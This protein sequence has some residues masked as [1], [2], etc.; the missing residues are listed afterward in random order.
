MLNTEQ[1]PLKSLTPHP[2]NVRQGDVGAIVE[3]L[4]AHGQYR[5]IVVQKST[6][7][8]LAGN[9]TFRAATALKWKDISVT[10]IDCD[11]DE[12][13]RI[14]LVDNRANDLASYDNGGLVEML[15]ALSNT[16]RK[17]EGTGFDLDDIDQ[18]L[19]DLDMEIIEPVINGDPD[20][21][22]D[23][24]L[25]KSVT[26]DIWILGNH[27]LICGDS[28]EPTTM[29][30]LM[31]GKEADII[32]TDPPY[33]VNIQ[34]RDLKQAEVRGRRKD[35]KGVMNDHLQGADLYNFLY[36]AFVNAKQATRAGGCWYVA[37]PPGDLMMQFG[38]AL[39]E[40]GLARHS[41]VW[42]KDS[43]VMGRADY[44]YRHEVIFY[45]WKEGAGHNWAGDRKQDSVWEIPRPKRSPEHPTMKP[46]ELITRALENSSNKGDIVLDPFGGSGSTLIAAHMTGRSARLIELDPNYCDVICARFQ[47]A[48]GIQP[49]AESTGN[50]HDFLAA[51]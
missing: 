38:N 36:A 17:L 43:L 13:L 45:G 33:G 11:D 20:E 3:S 8:I 40:L 42:V 4:K 49:I 22:P 51:K 6:G 21:M 29:D 26:G 12:A 32:W 23:Q 24:P 44:H 46:V 27:R 25:A 16:E 28:T 39:L 37:S 18:L 41:L 34:E 9:H 2:Q 35:G 14:L 47:K 50:P 5:P 30:K 1:A 7:H 15:Q 48:T 19:R 31:N 10:Y